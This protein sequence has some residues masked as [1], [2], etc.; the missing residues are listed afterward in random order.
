MLL[1]V[2]TCDQCGCWYH[3][4]C[5]GAREDEAN[6]EDNSFVCPKCINEPG[7]MLYVIYLSNTVL[8][9]VDFAVRNMVQT[10]TL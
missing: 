7:N 6:K 3:G 8:R 10:K 1:I 5:V 9:L 4:D 2:L